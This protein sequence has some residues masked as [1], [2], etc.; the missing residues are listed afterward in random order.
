MKKRNMFVNLDFRL[1]AYFLSGVIILF[2]ALALTG[3]LSVSP[4]IPNIFLVNIHSTGVNTTQVRVGYF[5]ICVKTTNHLECLSAVGR[6]NKSITEYLSNN[7]IKVSSDIRDLVSVGL[8]IQ[9]KIF[10]CLV[11]AA[12]VFFVVGLVA[13]ILLK[14]S[15]KK[16]NLNKPLQSKLFRAATMLFGAAATGLA[17]ASAVA[18]T[19]TANALSFAAS[20]TVIGNGKRHLSP[21]VALQVLQWLVVAFSVLFHL[22]LGSMFKIE[23]HVK[24]VGTLPLPGA[25]APPISSTPYAPRPQAHA[26]HSDDD[27]ESDQDS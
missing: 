25:M 12:G 14:R 4:G 6:N 2:Y 17:L 18:T 8:T 24:A 9:G 11:A 22:S 3:C 23:G 10:P 1:G 26:N 5:G 21:G 16:P 20:S 15:F 19:Q 7:A 27:Y 13:L